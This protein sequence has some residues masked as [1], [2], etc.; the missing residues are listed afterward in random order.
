MAIHQKS[1]EIMDENSSKDR[2][3]QEN[4]Q[5]K[6]LLDSSYPLLKWFRDACPGT[7]KHS[8]ALVGIVE[9]VSLEL[10]LDVD[11]MKVMGQYHDIGKALH[12][13]AFTENQGEENIHDKL[14]PWISYE[15]ISRHVSD[16]TMILIGDPNFPKDI[17]QKISQHHGTTLI[18]CFAE[19]AEDKERFRYQTQKPSSIEAMILMICDNIE[20]RSR[21]YI[22][23]GKKFDATEV[24]DMV[25]KELSSD[26]QLDALTFGDH[27]KLKIALEK[28]F[29]GTGQKR[30]SYPGDEDLKEE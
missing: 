11:V 10:G 9:G 19:N 2:G 7:F 20:A 27:R 23:N 8:H 1:E 28:E 4:I 6:D 15:L 17:I 25:I 13:D 26:G 30:V 16:T 18:K 12:P 5:L 3:D 22:Q 14:D 24:I 29:E 21:S